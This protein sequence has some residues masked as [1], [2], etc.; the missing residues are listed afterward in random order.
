MTS[1]FPD[2]ALSGE[3]PPEEVMKAF[4]MANQPQPQGWRPA[5]TL[6]LNGHKLAIAELTQKL[7]RAGLQPGSQE[8]MQAIQAAAQAGQAYAQ[9]PIG[10]T[11]L[12]GDRPDMIPPVRPADVFAGGTSYCAVCFVPQKQTSLLAAP[13]GWTPS[14]G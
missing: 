13:S 14:G 10:A 3:Q 7:G 12:N 11:G 1:D 2:G 9:D 5:C 6:C 4:R 8:F